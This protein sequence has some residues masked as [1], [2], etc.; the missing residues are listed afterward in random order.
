[1][2]ARLIAGLRPTRFAVLATAIHVLLCTT[3]V[4]QFE[5]PEFLAECRAA[6]VGHAVSSPSGWIDYRAGSDAIILAAP[7]G[8]RGRPREYPV[9]GVNDGVL[10][11]DSNT[12]RLAIA[13]AEQLAELRDSNPHLVICNL[14]RRYLDANR[15]E[16]AACASDSPARTDWH[17]YQH[18]IQAAKERILRSPGRGL[19]IEVH[20]HGHAIPRLELGYLLRARD[21]DLRD[22]AFEAAA[23]RSSIREIIAHGQLSGN[24]LLRGSRS[25]GAYLEQQ[26]LDSVPSQAVPSPGE[27]DY[28]NGGWNTRLHGSRDG[29]VISS[30]QIEFHKPGIRDSNEAIDRTARRVA[31]ALNRFLEQHYPRRTDD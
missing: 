15:P 7:H 8:G 28:F 24:D 26:E 25:L 10:I 16:D 29:G 30:I 18:A 1:M 17:C 9:R 3:A 11:S 23:D 5:S 14:H 12:D 19:F 27:A 21:F 31:A 22:E 2:R 4:A 6:E 20:G 13:I